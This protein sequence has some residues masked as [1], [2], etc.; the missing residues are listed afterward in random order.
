M[1]QAPTATPPM[2]EPDP[3]LTPTRMRSR[4]GI[5]SISTLKECEWMVDIA[6]SYR[7]TDTSVRTTTA[8]LT[9]PMPATSA[10]SQAAG[11][12]RTVPAGRV[13]PEVRDTVRPATTEPGAR[14]ATA[15]RYLLAGIRPALGWVFLW[16]FLDKASGLGFATPSERACFNGGSP[17][18]GFLGS[19]KGP[20]SRGRL[21]SRLTVAQPFVACPPRR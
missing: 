10:G 12:G 4:V 7:S 8:P 17:T 9:G 6:R 15:A 18:N 13:R 2:M 5:R 1:R 20:F 16:A 3:A 14:A 11:A 21:R 19:A